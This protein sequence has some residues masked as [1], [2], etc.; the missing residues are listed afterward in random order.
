MKEKID[1]RI[2]CVALVCLTILEVYALSKGF[3]GTL[4]MIVFAIIAAAIG[5]VIPNPFKIT[6]K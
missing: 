5:I 6:H 2:I 3:N 4:L 1:Y